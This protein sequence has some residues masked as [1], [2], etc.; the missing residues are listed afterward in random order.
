MHLNLIS[1]EFFK[2]TTPG[3]SHFL[4]SYGLAIRHSLPYITHIKLINVIWHG[5]HG[6]VC[7]TRSGMDRMAWYVK[8]DE[9][10]A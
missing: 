3:T 7:Q 9:T 8:L 6:M 10:S 5:S 1:L 2:T 4:Y